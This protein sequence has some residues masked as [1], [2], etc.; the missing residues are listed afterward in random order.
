M[1][2]LAFIRATPE[3][4]QQQQESRLKEMMKKAPTISE[5]PEPTR[6]P[7]T[8]TKLEATAAPPD[9]LEA[10][11]KSRIEVLLSKIKADYAD[12]MP[13]DLPAGLPPSRTVD[14]EI[15]IEPGCGSVAPSNSD[16]GSGDGL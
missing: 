7:E 8:C 3:T 10:D 1:G 11:L 4:S 12:V 5:K 14:H 2:F 16:L 9:H 15:E 13:G 6:L